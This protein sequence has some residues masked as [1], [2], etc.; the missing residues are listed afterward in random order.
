VEELLFARFR[1]KM[2]QRVLVKNLFCVP[3]LSAVRC[4]Q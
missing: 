2:S 4:V 1:K 3:Q